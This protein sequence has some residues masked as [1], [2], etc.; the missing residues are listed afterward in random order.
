MRSSRLEA[1]SDGVFAIAATLLVLELRVPAEATDLSGALLR[2][3]PAYAAYLVSFVTIGI[4]WVNHHTLLEHCRR[5]DRR[6]LY[7]NLMLLVAVGIV[8]FPTALVGQYI[9]SEH[10]ATAALVVYGLGGMLIAI[11]FTGVFLYATH[12]QRLVGDDAAARRIRQEGR[13]FPIGLAAYTAGI[14]LAFVAPLAS[15]AVYGLTAL[16]YALPLLPLPER[17][18]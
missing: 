6:F 14:A 13:L 8:P 4:I 2:L 17:G 7:L 12:D 15:L 5:V 18:P 16:F 11:A 10:G 1:F 9:L 3:W